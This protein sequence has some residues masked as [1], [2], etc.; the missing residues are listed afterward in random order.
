MTDHRVPRKKQQ[1]L[2]NVGKE[3]KPYQKLAFRYERVFETQALACGKM[4]PTQ[5]TCHSLKSRR[6]S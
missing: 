2:G 1:E 6:T 4:A 3:K 5:S